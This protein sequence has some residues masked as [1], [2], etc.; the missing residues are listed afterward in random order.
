MIVWSIFLTV[1]H[2]IGWSKMNETLYDT[3]RYVIE[4]SV[5]PKIG[6]VLWC[7][8]PFSTIFQLYHGGQFYW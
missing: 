8:M 6:L 1:L 3:I 4:L 5:S 7:F 2:I